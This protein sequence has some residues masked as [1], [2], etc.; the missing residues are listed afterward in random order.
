MD[1]RRFGIALIAFSAVAG[2]A[3]DPGP[4][5]FTDVA[6]AAGIGFDHVN[7]ATGEYFL[8][9]TMGAG[10]AFLDYDAD[11]DLDIYLVN[12]GKSPKAV[13]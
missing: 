10:G 4:V 13:G 11:G 9:E 6:V 8:V 3:G 12:S 5:S 2:C 7:G 1:A